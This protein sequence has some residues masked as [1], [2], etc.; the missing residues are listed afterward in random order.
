MIVAHIPPTR[1]GELIDGKWAADDRMPDTVDND[2]VAP[3]NPD[4]FAIGFY[5][6]TL[7]R[8]SARKKRSMNNMNSTDGTRR[9][10][11]V[12]EATW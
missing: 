2:V 10:S 8:T 5:A 1:S 7:A 4:D 11:A 12:I 9:I 3:G 6:P